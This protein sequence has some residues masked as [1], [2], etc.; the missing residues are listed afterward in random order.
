[1]E[2]ALYCGSCVARRKDNTCG[3]H[4]REEIPA[5]AACSEEVKKS[6]IVPGNRFAHTSGVIFTVKCVAYDISVFDHVGPTDP[7]I[8]LEGK[9][10]GKIFFCPLEK[11]VRV[12]LDEDMR[13]VQ[14]FAF[15]TEEEA[16]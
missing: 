13:R 4:S 2:T 9:A 16:K 3:L 10:D 1:M 14:Q 8:I 6:R 12:T 7:Q 5:G 11:F 15:V